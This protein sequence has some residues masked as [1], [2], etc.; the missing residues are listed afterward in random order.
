MPQG[1]QAGV[2]RHGGQLAEGAAGVLKVAVDTGTVD[3]SLSAAA[4][5]L[6]QGSLA[7]ADR[8]AIALAEGAAG[9][10]MV[11]VEAGTGNPSQLAAAGM[12]LRD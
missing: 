7:G 10:T 11:A 8:P 9:V 5:L 12:T 4:G 2:T 1:L 3:P 6:L